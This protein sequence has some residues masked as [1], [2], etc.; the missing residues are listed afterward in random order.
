MAISLVFVT[1]GGQQWAEVEVEHD[2]YATEAQIAA[3]A[4]DVF[5]HAATYEVGNQ[6]FS[7][8]DCQDRMERSHE[9]S[10]RHAP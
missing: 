2:A 1:F 6:S 7:A 10:A 9:A 5:A 8:D 3:I 4:W